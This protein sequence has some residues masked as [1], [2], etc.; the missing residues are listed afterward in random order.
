MV[1]G[2]KRFGIS[3]R[4]NQG[5]AKRLIYKKL[6]SIRQSCQ[7]AVSKKQALPAASDYNWQSLEALWL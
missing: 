3:R 5:S 1:S 6:I 2:L 4:G 7:Q